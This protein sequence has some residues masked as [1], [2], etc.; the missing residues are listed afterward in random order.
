V[1]EMRG[2]LSGKANHRCEITSEQMARLLAELGRGGYP[3]ESD[4]WVYAYRD[5]FSFTV[6]E[7]ITV[8]KAGGK[9]A[10][11]DASLMQSLL[12][13]IR[14]PLTAARKDDIVHAFAP[15]KYLPLLE[16]ALQ[17]RS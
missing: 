2:R 3:Y 16:T 10:G 4:D 15:S 5:V 17:Q 1:A 14:E 9:Y 6:D 11:Q 7:A 12:P 8:A 13:A